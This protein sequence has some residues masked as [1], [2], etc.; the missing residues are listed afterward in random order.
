V[1]HENWRYAEWGSPDA[2]ELYD[3]KK[4]PKE[5]HNLATNPEFAPVVKELSKK[6]SD[7]LP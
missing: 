5:Y 6:L 7:R 1:R 2:A 4:D 3:L